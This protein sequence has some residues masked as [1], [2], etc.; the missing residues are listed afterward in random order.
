MSVLETP[1][2]VFRGRVTW[3]PIVTNN[4]PA[5]YDE[6]SSETVFDPGESVT[7]FRTAA[8]ARVGAGG[9][10]NPHGTH[11]SAFY[12]TTIVGVDTGFKEQKRVPGKRQ[13]C[14]CAFGR[15]DLLLCTLDTSYDR[16]DKQS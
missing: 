8:I 14:E 4:L 5:Q 9:N 16:P 11:R 10:W 3:D 15:R 6:N 7:A 2:F 1:R 13:R 12:E